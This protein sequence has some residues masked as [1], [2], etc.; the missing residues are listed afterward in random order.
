MKGT[1]TYVEQQ[2]TN[3]IDTVKG[4]L[5][6]YLVYSQAEYVKVMQIVL[7]SVSSTNMTT[8]LGN[9][10]LVASTVET[11]WGTTQDIFEWIYTINGIAVQ[12]NALTITLEDGL[13][14]TLQDTWGLYKIGSSSV[15]ISQEEAVAIAR[16]AA[17]DYTLEVWL[18]EWV[19]V[20]FN[21][22][23]DY[24][25]VDFFTYPREA[26]TAFP[27]WD[28]EVYFDKSYY[29]VQGLR[30]GIWADTGEIAFCNELSYGG[31]SIDEITPLP[32]QSNGSN[33]YILAVFVAIIAVIVISTVMLRKK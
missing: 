10:K 17:T 4:I 32:Q 12:Q 5:D 3:A 7:S 16:K 9:V 29:S 33:W 18:G 1:P 25:S 31:G 2:T 6:R 11:P 8:T 30:F 22:R 28:I 21:L 20:P 24:V 19:E 14:T 13:F 26:L 27:L 23:D 15:N